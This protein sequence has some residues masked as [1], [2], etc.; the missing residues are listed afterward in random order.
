MTNKIAQGYN[1]VCVCGVWGHCDIV[2]MLIEFPIIPRINKASA[3]QSS[4]LSMHSWQGR[5]LFAP[6]QQIM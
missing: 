5:D 4:P 6:R 1:Y 3:S 2:I